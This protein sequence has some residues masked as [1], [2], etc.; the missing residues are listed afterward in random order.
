MADDPVNPSFVPVRVPKE[1]CGDDDSD[2]DLDFSDQ[3]TD[4]LDFPD[5]PETTGSVPVP[6]E[7]SFL[8]SPS[9]TLNSSDPKEASINLQHI[10]EGSQSSKRQPTPPWEYENENDIFD[11]QLP[12]QY[13]F[14]PEAGSGSSASSLQSSS[15]GSGSAI[16]NLTKKHKK[17]LSLGGELADQPRIEDLIPLA[18][19]VDPKVKEIL[20][21]LNAFDVYNFMWQFVTDL[22]LTDPERRSQVVTVPAL[23]DPS[24]VAIVSEILDAVTLEDTLDEW[25]CIWELVIAPR[26]TEEEAAKFVSIRDSYFPSVKEKKERKKENAQS[27]YE[28]GEEGLMYYDDPGFQWPLKPVAKYSTRED[29]ETKSKKSKNLE[30][31]TKKE[32]KLAMEFEKIQTILD[33]SLPK[34]VL[35]QLQRHK[36]PDDEVIDDSADIPGP[37]GGVTVASHLRRR[38][39]RAKKGGRFAGSTKQEPIRTAESRPEETFD[40]TAIAKLAEGLFDPDEIKCPCLPQSS[41]PDPNKPITL[42]EMVKRIAREADHRTNCSGEH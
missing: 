21:Q 38:D 2:S 17:T 37:S 11:N 5:V 6:P 13:H 39:G 8:E 33:A 30:G 26:L 7:N 1:R 34:E 36:V 22:S 19:A 27:D 24:I 29:D 31:P 40:D 4:A 23:S 10:L 14:N 12:Q 41:A 9:P 16:D 28:D 3:F 42:A 15:Y 35:S 18:P 32:R 20:G 25:V